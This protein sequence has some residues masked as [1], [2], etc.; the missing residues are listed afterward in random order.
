MESDVNRLSK[1]VEREPF[2]HIPLHFEELKSYTLEGGPRL[3]ENSNGIL[4]PSVTTA[5]GDMKKDTLDAWRAKIGLEEAN[6]IGRMAAAKG[7]RLHTL[8]ENYLNNEKFYMKGSFPDDMELFV[9][10][11][12]ELDANVRVVYAQEFPMYSTDLGVAGRCDL[13][14]DYKGCP[15][16]VDFKSS[17]KA[18]REDWIE[19]YFFQATAYCMMINEIKGID[20]KN[21]AIL[22]ASPD[23]LQVFHKSTDEYIE[24]TR[25]YFK[26]YHAK[27]G[28][29]QEKFREMIGNQ[30]YDV[31]S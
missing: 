3:Y 26:S 5:L 16:V 31:R 11:R 2:K 8:C 25:N 17:S 22:I 12:P 1:Q 30:Q 24:Q 20:V 6:K 28:Y 10:M 15:T 21:F 9:K 7:T 18:K 27:H 29:S 13:F 4:F 14:C 23:G 19:N